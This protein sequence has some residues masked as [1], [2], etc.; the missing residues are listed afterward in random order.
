[1]PGSPLIVETVQLKEEFIMALYDGTSGDDVLTGTDDDDNLIGLAGDDQLSGGAGE[2]YLQPR[3]GIDTI[4]RGD[5]W[6]MLSYRWD[7][8]ANSGITVS[9][10]GEG[11]GTVV[12]WNGDADTYSEIEGI[13]GTEFSDVM[14]GSDGE[15]F[16]SNLG[17]DDF[18]S[19]GIGDDY[20]EMGGGSDT[21]DGGAD[22][23]VM[24]YSTAEATGAI[25]VVFTSVGAGTVLDWSGGT[26]TFTNIEEVEGFH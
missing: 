25:T 11:A 17:G 2:D 5:D 12:D 16:F 7:V 18:V 19:G 4:F 15:E 23:D 13:E 22:H 8:D 6:D 24:S 3:S 26:D 20:F 1:M 9:S 10:T 21:V 14:T